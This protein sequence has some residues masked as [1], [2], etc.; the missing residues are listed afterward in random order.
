MEYGDF[1]I[2]EF[3]GRADP[4]AQTFFVTGMKG[5]MFVPNIKVYFRHVPA[6][7]NNN[8]VTLQIREVVNGSPSTTVV[9][10]GSRHLRRSEVFCSN[11]NV[12]GT[13]NFIA[14]T[15]KFRNLVHLENDKEYAIVLVPD[16]DDPNY[17]AYTGKL[18]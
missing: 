1:F 2:D 10:N 3:C 11:T 6:E 18:G 12:D 9:P 13:H 15:F 8:G 5:G 4:I 17:I 7:G 14:T 16:A